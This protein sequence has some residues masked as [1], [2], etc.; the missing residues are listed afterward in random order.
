MAHGA[1][2]IDRHLE[3]VAKVFPLLA[4]VIDNRPIDGAIENLQEPPELGKIKGR[5]HFRIGWP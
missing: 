5:Y 2:M 3:V 1:A 4:A